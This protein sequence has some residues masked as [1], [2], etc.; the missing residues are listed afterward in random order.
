MNFYRISKYSPN[1]PIEKGCTS[2]EWTSISDVKAEQMS[3]YYRTEK[4]YIDTVEKIL[5]KS[6][7]TTVTICYLENHNATKW[8]E[9]DQLNR[10]KARE[11]IEDCLREKCWGQLNSDGFI[12]E[13]GYDYYMHIGCSLALSEIS[14]IANESNLFVEEWHRIEKINNNE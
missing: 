8:Q 6:G 9:G 4:N 3:T 2:E 5:I 14:Q 13:A 7:N 12:W 10:E 11:F 1:Q